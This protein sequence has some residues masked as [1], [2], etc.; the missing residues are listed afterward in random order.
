MSHQADD[1]AGLFKVLRH[2]RR[3]EKKMGFNEIMNG[4]DWLCIE[5]SHPINKSKSLCF[6]R[7]ISSSSCSFVQHTVLRNSLQ[8]ICTKSKKLCR[9]CQSMSFLTHDNVY[10]MCGRQSITSVIH[11]DIAWVHPSSLSKSCKVVPGNLMFLRNTD[12]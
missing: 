12:E 9:V 8:G 11:L 3:C 6:C 5:R 1:G 4:V 7:L 2:I 10:S